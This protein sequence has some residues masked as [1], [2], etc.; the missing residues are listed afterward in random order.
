[1]AVYYS[2]F[3]IKVILSFWN[4]LLLAKT[5]IRVNN[6]WPTCN[7]P[8]I[9]IQ[10]SVEKLFF[11]SWKLLFCLFRFFHPRSSSVFH[12]REMYFRTTD[13]SICIGAYIF[14]YSGDC[15]LHMSVDTDVFFF[16]LENV[17]CKLRINESNVL[18]LALIQLSIL[19]LSINNNF[20]WLLIWLLSIFRKCS[21]LLLILY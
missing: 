21:I 12:V 4:W 19:Y 20:Y 1:M 15:R 8:S 10:F 5:F 17:N 18:H 2:S 16:L 14:V 13:Y 9:M 3:P 11:S 6:L 7:C